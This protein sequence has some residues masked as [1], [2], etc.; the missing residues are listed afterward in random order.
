MPCWKYSSG[1]V[2]LLPGNS[3]FCMWMCCRSRDHGEGL[4][5]PSPRNTAVCRSACIPEPPCV[6]NARHQMLSTYQRTA[7]ETTRKCSEQRLHGPP[8]IPMSSTRFFASRCWQT[9]AH[10]PR[11]HRPRSGVSP[12]SSDA[13]PSFSK[14]RPRRVSTASEAKWL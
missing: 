5:Q 4:F 13:L 6:K 7:C 14:D 8:R 12:H 10:N 9:P 11:A 2:G 3:V 1:L